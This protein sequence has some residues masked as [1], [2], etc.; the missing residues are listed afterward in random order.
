MKILA[1][2]TSTKY[3]CL[4]LLDGDKAYAYTLLTST[5]LSVLIAVTIRRAL[6]ALN[7]EARDFDY[8][9]CG[10]GPGSFTGLRVGVATIKGLSWAVNK[11]VIGIP[12]LDI[13]AENFDRDEGQIVPAID[14]RRGLIYS[15]VY[16]KEGGAVKRASPYMLLSADELSRKVRPSSF[17]LGDAIE[18]YRADFIR[19]IK[20][21][22]LLEKDYWYP[23]PR[24]LLALAQ[25]K[26]RRKEGISNAL[27]IKPL[28]LYPKECQIRKP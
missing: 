27:K 3:L 12:T 4:G 20:R 9:A 13:L 7:L 11:P 22:N 15:A 1:I 6:D 23:H 2:D 17:L 18:N 16:R 19:K 10:T 24:H 14:A 26:I 8:F 5:R 28:Y 25:E 21:V